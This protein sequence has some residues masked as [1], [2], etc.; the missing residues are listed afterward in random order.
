MGRRFDALVVLAG[1]LALLGLC[2]DA[3]AQ[4]KQPPVDF[5]REVRAIL[6]KNCYACH[7]PDDEHRKAGLR[8][9]LREAA[10][11]T[12]ES[13]AKAVVPGKIDDSEL[14]ARIA[15]DDPAERM[16]PKGSGRTLTEAEIGILKRW[17]AEG[18]SYAEHWSF[19]KPLRPPLPPV[20][21]TAWPKNGIDHF[22]LARLEQAGLVPAP[23]ADRYTLIR[24]LSLD[25][26]GLPPTPKEVQAFVNDHSAD[27][28]EQL[29]DRLMA[30][31]AFGERWARMW[32][33]LAR[34]ADSKG[35]GSDPLRTIWRYRDWVID[36]FNTNMA[37]EPV[38]G[39]TDRRRFIAGRDARA[40]DRHGVSP[41]HH[42][43]HRR[44]NGRRG[45]PRRGR[46]R[47]GR[48]DD[49]GVDGGHTGMREMPQP[50]VRPLQPGRIL[51]VFRHLQSDRRQRPARRI[52]GDSGAVR[53][54]QIEAGWDRR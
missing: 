37:F 50:Q 16:P 26:R 49:A 48:Y 52:A 45:V 35:L 41:E 24:R 20:K 38:H 32:L 18:A 39:R 1:S 2:R 42:D 19:V 12:L 53:T 29:V 13:G 17:I 21:Q 10:L 36:A 30:D 34:Y 5:N 33:D 47:P 46:E 4:E 51:S 44:G 40:T 43:E 3:V 15:S 54:G 22:I 28:Y 14:V 9:D 31:A 7:G 6:S 27:A 11:K 25:L 8:F 23:E